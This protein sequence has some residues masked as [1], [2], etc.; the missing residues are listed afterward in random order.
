[1]ASILNVFSTLEEGSIL[2]KQSDATALTRQKLKIK[3]KQKPII[4][5]KIIQWLT[6]NLASMG[7]KDLKDVVHE[8]YA[9]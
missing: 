3:Q 5:E 8:K 1:M 2:R 6:K 4:E 7:M 9:D